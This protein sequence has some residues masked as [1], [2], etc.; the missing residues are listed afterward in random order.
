MNGIENII[1]KISDE[2]AAEIDSINADAE[3][4]IAEIKAACEKKAQD[5]YNSIVAKGISDAETRIK[6]LDSVAQ[7]D[8]KKTVLAAKQGLVDMAFSRAAEMAAQLPENEYVEFLASLA[9]KAAENGDEKVILSPAD[10]TRYG[11]SVCIKANE[12]LSAEG[13]NA[14]LTLSERT[15][16]ITGGLILLLGSGD[17]EVNCS[18]DTL[19]GTARHDLA[20]KVAS[21]L[22]D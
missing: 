17:V 4:K 19:V 15:A 3:A 11:K 7:L 6:R 18:I 1:A 9:A 8:S 12:I 5:E 10:R 21:V 22:F 2:C 14:S 13:R 16:D 20:A